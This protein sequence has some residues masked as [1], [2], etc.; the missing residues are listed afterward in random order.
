MK[1]N[2]DYKASADLHR[3][4]RAFNVDDYV[5]VCL[6]PEQFPH[7]TVKKLHARNA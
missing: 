5:M 2:F 3:R 6:R 4:F 1:I 7:E